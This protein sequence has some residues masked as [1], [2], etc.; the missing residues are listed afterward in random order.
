VRR[1]NDAERCGGRY[2][3]EAVEHRFGIGDVLAISNVR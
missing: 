3:L 1:D 2:P